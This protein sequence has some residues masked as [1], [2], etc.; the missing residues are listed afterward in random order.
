MGSVENRNSETAQGSTA[1]QP[2]GLQTNL[3]TA[4]V[5]S[6]HH[7]RVF[8]PTVLR[9]EPLKAADYKMRTCLMPG[10]EKKAL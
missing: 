3:T 4:Q 1:S 10:E 7:Y 6:A 9:A 5:N 2:K 8:V